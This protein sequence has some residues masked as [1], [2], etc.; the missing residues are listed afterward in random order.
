[1]S[2][3]VPG[4]HDLVVGYYEQWAVFGPNVSVDD[5]PL[6]R[7]SHL[8]YE[9]ATLDGDGNL[10]LGQPV[11]DIYAQSPEDDMSQ[12][13]FAGNFQSLVRAKRRYPKL[14]TLLS[15]GGWQRT[16]HFSRIAADP[17]LREVAVESIYQ[18]LK[19]YQFDGIDFYWLFTGEANDS[20]GPVRSADA[21]NYRMFLQ[22]LRGKFDQHEQAFKQ[23]LWLTSSMD[24][25][26][27][28]APETFAQAAAFVDFFH[29]NT[30]QFVGSWSPMTGH[31]S[32]LQ[33]PARSAD[34]GSVSEVIMSL[35][36]AGV[37]PAKL[38]INVT[39]F[40][41]GWQGI[42]TSLASAEQPFS[43]QGLYQPAERL[44]WGSWETDEHATL[45]MYSRDHLHQIL[46]Q[47]GYQQFWDEQA[48]A[49]FIFNG[50]RFGG[51]FI[52]YESPRAVKQKIAFVR[53]QGLAG[54]GLRSLHNDNR[55]AANSLL[56][57]IYRETFPVRG[58]WLDTQ[59]FLS[60]YQHVLRGFGIFIFAI[61]GF[62]LVLAYRQHRNALA[63]LAVQRTY[64]KTT[65]QLQQMEWALSQ[66]RQLHNSHSDQA[67]HLNLDE[68]AQLYR[69]VS[70]LMGPVNTLLRET[71]MGVVPR[72]SAPREVDLREILLHVSA[73]VS[74]QHAQGRTRFHVEQH[75]AGFVYVDESYLIQLL[76]SVIY[77]LLENASEQDRV[78]LL[79][80]D[81]NG[82]RVQ[83]RVYNTEAS[84]RGLR[85]QDF[86]RLQDLY[87]LAH[88]LGVQLHQQM[89]ASL[90]FEWDVQRGQGVADDS[91]MVRWWDELRL[92]SAST[93][94]EQ[95][96]PRMAVEQDSY[97]ELVENF[98]AQEIDAQESSADVTKLLERACR[99]FS[100]SIDR[101]LK[102]SIF[103]GEQLLVMV[104][105]AEQSD[106]QLPAEN[107][108]NMHEQDFTSGELN[109]HITSAEPLS[110]S[111][112]R[113]FSVLINQI[114][115]VRKTLK[116]LV[117]EP[118]LLSELYEVAKHKDKIL[119]MQA[120]GGYTNVVYA[121][122]KKTAVMSS[123]L[124]TI[125]QYFDDDTLLQVHRSY[126]INPKR[127]EK[128]QRQSNYR[129][130]A[131]VDT[132][133]IPISRTYVPLLKAQYPFW[134]VATSD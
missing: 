72:V 94:T 92:A 40:A 80:D 12:Q 51:H 15:I 112:V 11:A 120:D 61:V 93:V 101:S 114:Q 87:R 60:R 32:P 91:N 115:L 118:A 6:G 108:A 102:F 34:R 42:D 83:F 17:A 96:A 55:Y 105:T 85:Q 13:D 84:I 74:E 19:R 79:V 7:L 62:F 20:V 99:F 95:A 49:S 63:R 121:G 117:R 52:S 23:H 33:A 69:Q 8:V 113:Y 37:P 64:D 21:Q 14:R 27:L 57:S 97:L 1:M 98:T 125:K 56:A 59:D 126:L 128:V 41:Q 38:V 82:G 30:S 24:S 18:A 131:V 25:G 54:I 35:I 127:V 5:L 36:E 122:A 47:P 76:L 77:L 31:L 9:G 67:T 26:A 90:S 68:L 58:L 132:Q 53:E 73:L 50:E 2:T 75:T 116:E 48:Q 70:N 119:Y 65:F 71:N 123:R 4:Y 103:Q 10:R 88:G 133:L 100:V 107:A 89:D 134:F 3:A 29:V 124:R 86:A 43:E 66:L 129:Y 109:F 106:T 16:E 110:D 78:V 28:A 45:G 39:S 46:K 104:D 44:S 130:E 111:D 81:K 22:L